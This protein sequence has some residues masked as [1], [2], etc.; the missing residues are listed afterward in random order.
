MTARPPIAGFDEIMC[1]E[2]PLLK[3]SVLF[4][5]K[6]EILAV[7][8]GASKPHNHRN[9]VRPSVRHPA[10]TSSPI[11]RLPLP[12]CSHHPG[13]IMKLAVLEK[14]DLFD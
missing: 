5:H 11:S 2:S 7:H 12:H 4:A 10:S 9:I 8:K 3:C 6:E 14:E 13:A 1:D